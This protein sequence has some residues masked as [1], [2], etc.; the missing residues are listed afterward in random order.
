VKKEKKEKFETK[1]VACGAVARLAASDWWDGKVQLRTNRHW[2]STGAL[3]R[4]EMVCV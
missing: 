4:C 2:G 3:L 1:C